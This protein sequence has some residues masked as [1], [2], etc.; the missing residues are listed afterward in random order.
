[1]KISELIETLKHI[2][3]EIGNV[4]VVLS[5]DSEGNSWGTLQAPHSFRL[6]RSSCLVRNLKGDKVLG[7]T[8]YPFADGF[9]DEFEALKYKGGKY[10][11]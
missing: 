4:P 1:M 8:I 6:V 5:C 9:R 2:E 11:N 7:L 3:E 10:G